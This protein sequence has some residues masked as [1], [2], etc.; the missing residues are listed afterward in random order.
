MTNDHMTPGTAGWDA[1]PPIDLPDY[2]LLTSCSAL[3]MARVLPRMAVLLPGQ[4]AHQVFPDVSRWGEADSD[5]LA[6]IERW[7]RWI[8]WNPVPGAS[9]YAVRRC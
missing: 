4:L 1:P 9:G 8:S 6:D 5:P 3:A 2:D 7:K